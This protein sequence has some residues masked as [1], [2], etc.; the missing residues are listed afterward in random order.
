[1]SSQSPSTRTTS[2][3]VP[4]TF[5]ACLLGHHHARPAVPQHASEPLRRQLGIQRH[6]GSPRFQHPKGAQHQLHCP[7]PRRARLVPP[8]PPPAPQVPRQLVGLVVQLAVAQLANPVANRQPPP[9]DAAASPEK[10]SCT[11]ERSP[12]HDPSRSTPPAPDDAPT[13][14]ASRAATLAAPGSP[15]HALQQPPVV[16]EQPLHASTHRTAPCCTRRREEPLRRV[17]RVEGQVELGHVRVDPH[18]L[19]GQPRRRRLTPRRL[20]LLEDEGHLEER[21]SAQV[22]LRMQLLDQPL[23]R[24]VLVL[25]RT[26]DDAAHAREQLAEGRIPGEVG[27]QDERVREEADERLQLGRVSGRRS[28]SPRRRRP[29]PCTG[30]AGPGRPPAAP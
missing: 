30:A 2:S 13:P 19:E 1:M 22:A 21:R 5:E 28:G 14:P 27:A 8:D 9:A 6:V 24:E 16:P 7:S 12:P 15:R 20:G 26:Q 10:R 29:A 11:G 25:V 17:G 4:E 18:R 23:E 3:P